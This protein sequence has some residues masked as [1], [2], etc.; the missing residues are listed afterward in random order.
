MKGVDKT[1]KDRH[2]LPMH[3]VLTWWRLLFLLPPLHLGI[4]VGLLCSTAFAQPKM[5]I[6]RLS[7][8]PTFARG[9]P[10]AVRVAGDYAY[11]AIRR[12]D[13]SG[14]LAVLDIH[15]PAKPRLSGHLGTSGSVL[16]VDVV[17]PFAY[18]AGSNGLQV[19]SVSDPGKPML[20]GSAQVGGFAWDVHVVSHYA[21]V[22]SVE[23]L[24]AV[25]IAD[26]T[27][28]V[29]VGT[30]P[31]D[32]AKRFQI[33]NSMAYVAAGDRLEIIRLG[34]DTNLTHAGTLPAPTQNAINDVRVRGHYAFLANT[35]LTVVDVMDPLHPVVMAHRPAGD[36]SSPALTVEGDY[37]YVVTDFDSVVVFD[38]SDPVHPV[39]LGTAYTAE[40]P[41]DLE[42]VG[43]Y[44]YVAADQSG[45]A[46]L[47]VSNRLHPTP[48]GGY[49]LS[50]YTSELEIHGD[51]AYLADQGGGLEILDVSNPANPTFVGNFFTGGYVSHVQLADTNL[52]VLDLF[53]G[54]FILDVSHPA[55]PR[56]IGQTTNLDAANAFQLVGS[57]AYVA[58]NSGLHIIDVS[59]PANSVEVSSWMS[60]GEFAP[61]VSVHVTGNT[62]YVGLDRDPGIDQGVLDV[63]DASDP[64]LLRVLNPADNTWIAT[65]KEA[66]HYLLA[67][68]YSP[69][70]KVYDNSDPTNPTLVSTFPLSSSANS[71]TMAGSYAYVSEGYGGVQVL[72]AS[73]PVHLTSVGIFPA[74]DFVPSCAVAG[75]L[76]YVP[77][78]QGISVLPTAPG[79]QLT[80]EV[81]GTAGMPLT[82]E[83]NGAPTSWS[84]IFSTNAPGTPFWF[85][86]NDGKARAK[87]YRARQP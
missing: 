47:D 58:C 6:A 17:G 49:G 13:E 75:G 72:D 66:G 12:G 16:G 53:L 85:T 35:D 2:S 76:V 18:L 74:P 21:Y 42:V 9:R 63:S 54:L 44:A 50:G 24:V 27:H 78:R 51:I 60:P 39:D 64:K 55:D 43:N 82:I 11:V 45:L 30:Y 70:L 3:R 38:I 48:A 73:D 86:D 34:A 59:N 56:L 84:P 69:L 57:Y 15:Q 61:A 67:A 1:Y 68:D 87:F 65:F 5:S 36:F 31:M 28:P 25:D 83:A 77:A 81:E 32:R 33:V 40:S 37:A 4:A 19:I 71:I 29:R 46:V 52:F 62:A 23:G 80:L 10:Q 7:V 22:T 20:V 41:R 79:L 26:P 8:W 14:G